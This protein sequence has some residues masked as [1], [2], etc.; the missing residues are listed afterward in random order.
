MFFI[1]FLQKYEKNTDF[2][3]EKKPDQNNQV[4]GNLTSF[5]HNETP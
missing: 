3:L 1:N 2:L 4:W 5:F